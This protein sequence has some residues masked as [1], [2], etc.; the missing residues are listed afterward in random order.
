MAKSKKITRKELLK[1]PDEFMTLS[2]K[3]I[4][5]YMD[6][7]RQF[8]IAGIVLAGLII[9]A[10]AAGAWFR[11]INNRALSIYNTAYYNITQI[12]DPENDK[13]ALEES[14]EQFNE[15][16]DKYGRSRFADL[17]VAEIAYIDFLQGNYDEALS[18]YSRFLEKAPDASYKSMASLA[19]A[20][21]YE[22]IGEYENAAGI[23]TGMI[24]GQDDFFREQAML[25]LAR[26]HRLN[27][28]EEKSDEILREFVETFP[29]SNF[30]PLAKAFIRS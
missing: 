28:N 7:I 4:K 10:L 12:P 5:F 29:A 9:I 27:S 2:S 18:G 20:V 17:A 14:K 13:E 21:C 6:H 1:K 24:S 3:A 26:V 11:H 15:I 23:L 22:K 30:L 8:R 16:I 19:M 25:N